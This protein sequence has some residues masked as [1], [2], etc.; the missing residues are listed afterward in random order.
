MKVLSNRYS[1]GYSVGDHLFPFRTEKLSPTAPMVLHT[2]GRVGR[3]Q[4]FLQASFNRFVERGFF[5]VNFLEGRRVLSWNGGI[6]S[7]PEDDASSPGGD[8]S[9]RR[10]CQVGVRSPNLA[11]RKCI[12]FACQGIE[13]CQA[14]ADAGTRRPQVRVRSPNLAM[15]KC[16]V[17]ACQGIEPC[18]ANADAGTRLLIK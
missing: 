12:V 15:R 6:A 10:Y 8:A 7:S 9:P 13:P 11:I 16:I 2:R 14:N 3:R 5:C 1:G 18:Q 4:L 17:F